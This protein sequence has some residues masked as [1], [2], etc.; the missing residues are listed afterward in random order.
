LAKKK[1]KKREKKKKKKKKRR[2]E[3]ISV[4]F[5]K[6]KIKHDVYLLFLR[7]KSLQSLVE[8]FG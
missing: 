7:Y 3:G 2:G 8:N 1:E 4:L 5:L 6:N